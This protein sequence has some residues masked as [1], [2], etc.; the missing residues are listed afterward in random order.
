MESRF[1]SA[2]PWALALYCIMVLSG[3]ISASFRGLVNWPM[4]H[5]LAALF[6]VMWGGTAIR[7]Q[8]RYA[9]LIKQEERTSFRISPHVRYIIAS[10]V[11]V[12]AAVSGADI[13]SVLFVV[14]GI[15]VIVYR[16]VPPIIVGLVAVAMLA[17]VP[18]AEAVSGN[19]R[20][21]WMALYAFEA[22][23]IAVTAF[24]ADLFVRHRE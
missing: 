14:F 15:V 5:V 10:V 12:G 1:R 22:C 3:I 8:G 13:V 2:A 4:L 21:Q 20:A 9:A 19:I 7:R 23:T 18:L 11:M 6:A 17:A 24:T 16:R